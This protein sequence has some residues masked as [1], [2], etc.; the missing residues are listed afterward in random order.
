MPTKAELYKLTKEMLYA[1]CDGHCAFC[2]DELG[3][4]WCIWNIEPRETVITRQ[5]EIILGN[6]SYE[7]KLPA[8]K[9]C[10]GARIYHSHDKK[11]RIGIEEFRRAIAQD[12]EFLRDKS[13]NRGLY[14][15]ALRYG[16]IQETNNPIVFYFERVA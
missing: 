1:K 12:F 15:R 9:S 8:C 11:V 16:L 13:M 4:L 2:G 5:K 6:D 7:N 14:Q 10:N 3:D